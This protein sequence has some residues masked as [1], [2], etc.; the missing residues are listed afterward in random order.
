MLCSYPAHRLRK[1]CANM[2]HKMQK[3]FLA[4]VKNYFIGRGE[5]KDTTFKAKNSK[6]NPRPRTDI[7]RTEPLKAKDRN[8]RGQGQETKDTKRKCSPKKKKRSLKQ[9]SRQP[10][11]ENNRARRRQF[12]AKNQGL[13][14]KNK[15]G[16][17]KFSTGF[18]AFFKVK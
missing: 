13:F 9:F 17:Y 11:K 5:V 15:T 10:P 4:L 16:L 7:S 2:A 1:S 3:I 12:S 14:K 8:A 6:K 18:L